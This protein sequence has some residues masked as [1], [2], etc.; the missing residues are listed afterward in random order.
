MDLDKI[1][2]QTDLT[3]SP[4]PLDHVDFKAD[5]IEL[6]SFGFDV[7]VVLENLEIFYIYVSSEKLVKH[8]AGKINSLS[9][10]PVQRIK[11]TS[12]CISNKNDFGLLSIFLNSLVILYITKTSEEEKDEEEK[13]MTNKIEDNFLTIESTYEYY[14]FRVNS[15][16][17]LID[18][19]KEGEYIWHV[20]DE[21]RL[22]KSRIRRSSKGYIEIISNNDQI[23]LT[24]KSIIDINQFNNEQ[25]ILLQRNSIQFL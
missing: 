21:H 6:R 11:Y 7:L 12:L 13:I 24:E 25:L 1:K 9:D 4:P 15:S 17:I 20:D 18:Q 8:Y 23:I 22:I 10:T 19:G 16:L 5:I 14:D 3:E 2:K